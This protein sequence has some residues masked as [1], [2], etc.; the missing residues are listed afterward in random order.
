MT[1]Q[2]VLRVY[3]LGS[4]RI[5][6][7]GRSYPEN[8]WKSQ[9]ALEL[10]KYL[11]VHRDRVVSAEMMIEDLWPEFGP[12]HGRKRLYD[13]V[14]RL[15]QAIDHGN[16]DSYIT[17]TATGYC[18][19]PNG[20]YWL[21]WQRLTDLMQSPWGSE[22]ESESELRIL[23]EVVALYRGPFLAADI[24]QEWTQAPRERY[25]EMYL[26][27]LYRLAQ[28]FWSFGQDDDALELLRRGIDE[29]PYREELYLLTARIFITGKH[30]HDAMQTY[31]KY[32]KVM[33]RDLGLS[34]SKQ[35]QEDFWRLWADVDS[36]PG[37]M[38]SGPNPSSEPD[39]T[40]AMICSL[41][42]FRFL[43]SMETRHVTREAI[44]FTLLTITFSEAID[45]TV[46]GSILQKIAAGLRC[47]DA[48]AHG[49]LETIYVLLH[50]ASIDDRKVISARMHR[51]L[52]PT[53][54]GSVPKLEWKEINQAHQVELASSV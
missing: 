35:I 20:R 10:L 40:G 27:A 1:E 29:D 26:Q 33:K 54:T 2:G 6:V 31:R 30:W 42:S 41:E 9:K 32:E 14:Y 18:L 38:D 50:D 16:S 19:N 5:E 36:R 15:R 48:V 45:V 3:G 21:D 47:T 49:G 17:K 8:E 13:T 39:V 53:T 28:Q 52:A 12:G 43:C 23:Q 51:C 11:L 22:G 37:A 25:R 7:C 46:M 34:L 24:Y 44:R 4:F